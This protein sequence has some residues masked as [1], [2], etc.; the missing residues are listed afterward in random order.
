[1]SASRAFKGKRARFEGQ[2]ISV[3]TERVRSRMLL[4][5][6]IVA[7]RN[8]TRVRVKDS[9]TRPMPRIPEDDVREERRPCGAK[10]PHRRRPNIPDDAA[11]KIGERDDNARASPLDPRFDWANP[12]RDC[13][14]KAQGRGV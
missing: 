4:E 5:R 8:V 11:M 3:R 12:T 10:A 2:R 7:E 9:E 6:V 13:R 1:M 14:T